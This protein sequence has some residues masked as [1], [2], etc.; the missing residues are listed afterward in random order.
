[1]TMEMRLRGIERSAIKTLRP[2]EGLTRPH[3]R[4]LS[5]EIHLCRGPGKPRGGCQ[6]NL[7]KTLF[8]W[9]TIR[10]NNHFHEN[11]TNNLPCLGDHSFDGLRRLEPACRRYPRSYSGDAIYTRP[12]SS[13]A[14]RNSCDDSS[15]APRALAAASSAAGGFR[16]IRRK[17]NSEH[18]RSATVNAC[19]DLSKTFAD[20]SGALRDGAVLTCECR[21]DDLDNALRQVVTHMRG[22]RDWSCGDR[23]TSGVNA[24]RR[25]DH[26][27]QPK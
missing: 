2:L 5:R 9:Q 21:R 27:R 15:R 18:P 14:C 1:M 13:C 24:G 16:V 7:S 17:R 10:L 23:A 11:R 6:G 19:K 20:P 25:R 4:I 3:P 12:S 26:W 8:G 22:D